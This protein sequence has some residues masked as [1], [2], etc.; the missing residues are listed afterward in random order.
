VED[1][2][3]LMKK[4]YKVVCP[5]CEKESYACKSLMMITG[6]ANTGWAA[7]P[8]C[9]QDMAM[10][11]NEE[12]QEFDAEKI[13]EVRKRALEKQWKRTGTVVKNSDD[14]YYEYVIIRHDGNIAFGV[15]AGREGGETLN[16]EFVFV[17]KDGKLT[18]GTY[19]DYI[20]QS[21][22]RI[23]NIRKSDP[24]WYN[25]IIGQLTS[26]DFMKFFEEFDN[27]EKPDGSRR[28]EEKR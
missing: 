6:M 21:R 5:A 19:E 11:F 23:E 1:I 12:K 26:S 20:S 22:R 7:C 9:G 24:E 4:R 14:R 28:E 27:I 25:K 8:G 2:E 3:Y 15:E 10:T 17:E 13:E 18:P 16:P